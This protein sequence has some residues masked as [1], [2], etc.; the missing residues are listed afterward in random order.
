MTLPPAERHLIFSMTSSACSILREYS[1]PQPNIY[2]H[3]CGA[4]CQ[5]RAGMSCYANPV[6]YTHTHLVT[7]TTLEANLKEY[8]YCI[9]VSDVLS[10]SGS[11]PSALAPP[12][13]AFIAVEP[14]SA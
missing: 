8:S 10:A 5:T 3:P 13:K 6:V 7:A 12:A 2:H 14:A 9:V 1:R 11:R 4:A